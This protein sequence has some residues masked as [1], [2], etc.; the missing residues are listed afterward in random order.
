M[1]IQRMEVVR[2]RR[3]GIMTRGETH[4][5]LIILAFHLVGAGVLSGLVLL[6][7]GRPGGTALIWELPCARDFVGALFWPLWHRDQPIAPRLDV[8]AAQWWTW[9]GASS[10]SHNP[11]WV[12]GLELALAALGI[13]LVW[14]TVAWLR[15]GGVWAL[16]PIVTRLGGRDLLPEDSARWAMLTDLEPRMVYDEIPGNTITIGT[17]AGKFVTVQPDRSS[18][19]FAPPDAGKTVTHALPNILAWS[20]PVIFTSVKPDLF[21]RAAA[22]QQ[23][24]GHLFTADPWGLVPWMP[25]LRWDPVSGC[26]RDI[27][28]AITRATIM[29]KT[30]GTINSPTKGNSNAAAW[31]FW[32]T[33]SGEYLG[34]ALYMADL[35]GR[36]MKEVVDWVADPGGQRMKQVLDVVSRIHPVPDKLGRPIQNFPTQ[37]EGRDNLVQILDYTINAYSFRRVQEFVSD[38]TFDFDSLLSGPN[39]LAVLL[40]EGDEGRIIAPLT[41]ALIVQVLDHAARMADRSPG[42]RLPQ[43]LLAMID[44]AGTSTPIPDLARRVST[45]RARAIHLSLL[46]QARSQLKEAYSDNEVDTFLVSTATRI[47]LPGMADGPTLKAFAELVEEEAYEK[48]TVTLDPDGRRSVQ[49][50]IERRPFLNEA[51][52]RTITV[53]SEPWI[54]RQARYVIN[55]LRFRLGLRLPYE[56]RFGV[57]LFHALRHPLRF[58]A[59]FYESHPVLG[60]MTDNEQFPVE[61]ATHVES[62]AFSTLYRRFRRRQERAIEKSRRRQAVW[63]ASQ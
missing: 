29:T 19:A 58:R 31:D 25:S 36:P 51:K 4:G 1:S 8:W 44:E 38:T 28:A 21:L 53:P 3:G 18:G 17:L 37:A 11:A 20:G 16:G 55:S 61:P 5:L 15:A 40:P 9:A 43:P 42:Q 46:F 60:L 62:R 6:Q 26:G 22:A 41:T 12:T 54:L 34:A 24:K 30:A 49:T 57:V 32:L 47:L 39:T 56:R 52:L 27:D 59:L 33:K 14:L 2:P 35:L 48:Q 63:R 7:G 45:Y 50:S 10:V 13:A 23:R